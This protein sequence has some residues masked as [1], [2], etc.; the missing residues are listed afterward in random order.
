MTEAIKTCKALTDNGFITT[1]ALWA[2]IVSFSVIAS[3]LNNVELSR[4][5]IHFAVVNFNTWPLL[6]QNSTKLAITKYTGPH[7]AWHFSTF[8]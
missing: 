6:I 3:G 1:A 2:K 5:E 7:F 4:L 8:C